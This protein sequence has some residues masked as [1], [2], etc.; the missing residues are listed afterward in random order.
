MGNVFLINTTNRNDLQ[1][2]TFNAKQRLLKS[3]I[4]LDSNST[5]WCFRED[6]A[7]GERSLRSRKVNRHADG[8]VT[9]NERR[10]Q[11]WVIRPVRS[12]AYVRRIQAP[13]QADQAPSFT[14]DESSEPQLPLSM[15]V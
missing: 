10:L 1:Q 2:G 9:V 8:S 14:L 13:A 3:F 15:W 6:P 12:P 7:I 4:L 11:A 5:E